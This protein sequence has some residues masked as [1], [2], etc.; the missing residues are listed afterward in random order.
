MMRMLVGIYTLYFL[1]K[2]CLP[3]LGQENLDAA[4]FLPVCGIPRNYIPKQQL[5][6][7]KNNYQGIIRASRCYSLAHAPLGEIRDSKAEPTR[8]SPDQVRQGAAGSR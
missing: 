2:N 4:V 7:P 5:D 8:R 1:F 6:H 3:Y